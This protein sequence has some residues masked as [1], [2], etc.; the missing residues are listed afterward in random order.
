MMM[1]FLALSVIPH[2]KL[3]DKGLVHVDTQEIDVKN[4]F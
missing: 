3:T 1:S 2:W 4:S